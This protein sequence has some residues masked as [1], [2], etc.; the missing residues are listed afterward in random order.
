M[1][2]TLILLFLLFM[3]CGINDYIGI[4]RVHIKKPI[5][6][7]SCDKI[8]KEF[9]SKISVYPSLTSNTYIIEI[10]D[11]SIDVRIDKE[12]KFFYNSK[13][14]GEQIFF[15]GKFKNGFRSGIFSIGKHEDPNNKG[16]FKCF[17][18]YI[19]TGT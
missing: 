14:D 15:G 13:I 10:L 7:A 11:Y 18:D 2:K 1:K 4:Y 5:S 8:S 3:S 19:V 12:G 16:Y 6:M 9:Q 17:D